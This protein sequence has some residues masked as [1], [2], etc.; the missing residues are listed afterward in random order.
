MSL[1]QNRGGDPEEGDQTERTERS[2]SISPC[3]EQQ[4]NNRGLEV[5]AQQDPS[6]LQRALSHF[7]LI[8]SKL[9]FLDRVGHEHSCNGL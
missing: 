4:G 1:V 8:V 5:G 6:G 3:E 7:N 9:S 2:L